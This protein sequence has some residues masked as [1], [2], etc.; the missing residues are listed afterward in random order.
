MEWVAE[1]PKLSTR[2][3]VPKYEYLKLLSIV[4][5][6]QLLHPY[7]IQTVQDLSP[8]DPDKRLDSCQFINVQRTENVNF[9]RESVFTDEKMQ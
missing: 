7:Q 6:G 1:V 9:G 4:I 5:K 3:L 2:C 8:L